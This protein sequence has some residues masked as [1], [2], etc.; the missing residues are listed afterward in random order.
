MSSR[1]Q[2]VGE[3][4]ISIHR[5]ERRRSSAIAVLADQRVN[6]WVFAESSYTG[7]EDDQLRTVGHRHAGAID[8][9]VAEPCAVKFMRIKINDSLLDGRIEY[10]EIDFQAQLS[11]TTEALDV[12]ADE[13][14]AHGKGT[15]SRAS[16]NGEHVDDGKMPQKTIGGVI[17]K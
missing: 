17:E 3:I 9:L 5:F 11:G 6:G 16:D 4:R 7:S 12:V 1:A 13:K 10:L 14:A 8:R 2:V 15:I